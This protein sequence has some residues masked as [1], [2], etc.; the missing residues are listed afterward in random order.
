MSLQKV[1][2]VCN[3]EDDMIARI[4]VTYYKDTVDYKWMREAFGGVNESRM[5]D[6]DE[7]DLD[8]ELACLT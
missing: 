6:I 8:R 4:Y 1:L 7:T 5:R 3:L 2:R